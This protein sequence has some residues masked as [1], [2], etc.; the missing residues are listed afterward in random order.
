MASRGGGV[1]AAIAMVVLLLVL[2]A[3]DYTPPLE[4]RPSL[5]LP[6]IGKVET[7]PE[8]WV[9]RTMSADYE[10]GRDDDGRSVL[11][12]T[13]TVTAVFQQAR[14]GTG[15]VRYLVGEYDGASTDPRVISVTDADG[16]PVDYTLGT[17]GPYVTITTTSP[18]VLDGDVVYLIEY[19]LRGVTTTSWSEDRERSTDRFEW[20]AFGPWK[21]P[22]AEMAVSVTLDRELQ[23]AQ[24]G[25]VVLLYSVLDFPFYADY[26]PQTAPGTYSDVL[27][28]NLPGSAFVGPVIEFAEGTFGGVQP[29]PNPGVILGLAFIPFGLAVLFLGAN[30]YFLVRS[31][32]PLRVRAKAPQSTPPQGLGP[33]DAAGL[34]GGGARAL[35]SQFLDFAARGVLY[36]VEAPAAVASILNLAGGRWRFAERGTAPLDETPWDAE[37]YRASFPYRLR[38]GE[39]ISASLGVRIAGLGQPRRREHGLTLRAPLPARRRLLMGQLPIAIAIVQMAFHRQA[40]DLVS[41]DQSELLAWL[42]FFACVMALASWLLVRFTRPVSA[43]GHQAAAE[44]AGLRAYMLL[45]RDERREVALDLQATDERLIGYAWLWGIETAWATD[46]VTGYASRRAAPP[47][48]FTPIASPSS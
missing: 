14:G 1:A 25:Q 2:V 36:V 42:A 29:G 32:L 12:A 6:D 9:I 40:S 23:A 17:D 22:A 37:L 30:L 38:Q 11:H 47:S 5:A 16:T 28:T 4:N 8:R 3:P 21:Q 35:E 44:F 45:P 20:N 34:M 39:G 33:M 41:A 48:W 7:E 13:E 27:T 31:R 24:R 19:E 10:L 18:E 26:L 46:L 43:A 15:I